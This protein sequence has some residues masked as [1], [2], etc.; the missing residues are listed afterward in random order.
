LAATAV[1][2]LA[3]CGGGGG[4]EATQ[5]ANV[6]PTV[7]IDTPIANAS[8]A[9]GATI[10]IG[11][12]ASD[13]DGN[14][15]RVEFYDGT[16]K[17]GEDTSAPFELV[18][19]NA[20]AGSHTITAR[21]VDNTGAVALSG[22]VPLTV[23]SAAPPPAPPPNQAPTVTITGPAGNNFKPN[24]P[25]TF[26]LAATAADADGSVAKVEFFK[27]DPKAPVFD[28]TT[29]VGPAAATGA[30]VSYQLQTTQPAGT[31]TF[32]ARATDN[33]GATGLS[34]SVQVVVNALP[35]VSLT[36]PSAGAKVSPGVSTTLRALASDAD[37]S[38]GK[39]EFLLNGTVIG[40]GTR[41]GATDEYTL[42]WSTTVEGVYNFTA[43]ATDN[44]GATQSTASVA[45]NVPANT[46]PTI[47]LDAPTA[48]ANAPTTLVLLAAASD[49]DG[50]VVS[51]EFFNGTTSL[52]LGTLDAAAGKYKRSVPVSASQAGTYTITARATDNLGAQR[53]TA[54]RSVTIA[55][56]L[57]PAVSIT[58]A[59]SFTLP[60]PV[61]IAASASDSD[62]IA[63]VEFFNGA[64]KLGESTA[65]PYQFTWSGVAAGTYSITARATDAVGSTATS[66]TQV[67]TVATPGLT[68]SC[69]D[70][71]A[72][73][74]S[75][76]AIVRIENGIALTR[77]GVQAYGRSTSDLLAANPTPSTAKGFA[78]TSGGLAELRLRRDT[79]G[80]PTTTA[81]LLSDLGL[82]WTGLT[83]RPRIIE[84]FDA[85]YGRV[86][87]NAQGVLVAATL[88]ASSNLAFYDY[89]S[90][91]VSATQED[92]ANNRYF[93]RAD[94]VRC[95]AGGLC[96]P[97]ETTGLVFSPGDWRTVGNDP[98]LLT[99]TRF[100]E[101]GD[102]HAG[103]GLDANGNPTW[104]TGGSGF[105]VP[106]P[107]SKGSREIRQWSYRY[108]NLASWFTQDTVN[109]AEWGG[110]DEHAKNRRGFVAYG[111]VTAPTSVPT[112]GTISYT[113]VVR[114]QQ[115]A[116]A[117][118]EPVPLMGLAT[119]TV[120]F[121]ARTVTVTLDN[122]V[123]DDGT[124][125]PVALVLS[126]TSTLRTS[127]EANYFGNAAAAATLSGGLG[128]RLFG[129]VSAGTGGNGPAEVGGT[130]ALQ[131]ATSGAAFIGGFIARR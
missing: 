116:D 101:D 2:A 34:A 126:S 5:P 14:V 78:L 16:T 12:T 47:T 74:C 100:H 25:A 114:G 65:A 58:S 130:F 108:A 51:V 53:T 42:P 118:S 86:Q 29:L 62:G 18:W 24:A 36:A 72:V 89:F 97:Q 90:R 40:T 63:K 103:N 38:I 109:I 48:G 120:D 115:V 125:T 7:S 110:L 129:P 88:P 44:D 28:A 104:L 20:T 17:L 106:M 23:T 41:V 107:G 98:D 15:A 112:T 87:L 123:R 45:L 117:A 60:A 49:A 33:A 32:V 95:V 102:I 9:A 84:T 35:T 105:G 81:L 13:A 67:L 6:A 76:D 92:Y 83:Q 113:G 3:A 56:N 85:T 52:G 69:A 71:A 94:P 46:L 99:A 79:G 131:N 64:T 30:T 22:S 96:V 57:P 121:A 19:T 11:A 43:R 55:P 91:G 59:T 21:A 68:M 93:P 26:T 54:S 27:V 128:G 75:G 122:M 1:A 66:A 61:V 127:G 31:Y 119:V 124:L 8:V 37:G 73:Q 80:T 10:R 50:N 111:D 70:G 82:S 4:G 77:S 39:V